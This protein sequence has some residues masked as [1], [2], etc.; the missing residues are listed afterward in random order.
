MLLLLIIEILYKCDIFLKTYLF[1]LIICFLVSCLKIN[2]QT[3]VVVC[4]RLFVGLCLSLFVLY[5]LIF[6]AV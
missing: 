4:G 1:V 2:L 6:S 5:C 3:F